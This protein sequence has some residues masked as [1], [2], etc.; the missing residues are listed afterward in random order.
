M[1][2]TTKTHEAI[3]PFPETELAV[4]C[5]GVEKSFRAGES[6]IHVL[7]ETDFWARSGEMTF[8]VGPS[9]CGKTTLISVF[10]AILSCEGGTV[11]V[12]GQDLRRTRRGR[13]AGFRLAN[14]GF[15]FQQF[16]LIPSLSAAENAS[17]PLVARGVAT[18]KAERRAAEMLERLG[19]KDQS[20]KMPAQLSGGQQQRVAIARA[21]V[22]DPKLLICDEPTASL[23]AASGK[24]V[25][26]LLKDV[27]LEEGRAVVVVTH[28]SRIFG[29]AD[30]VHHMADGQ[31]FK[32]ET[33]AQAAEAGVL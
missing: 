26:E 14:L 17:L 1:V 10:G 19:L 22:H 20:R 23:D 8:L 3:A 21:L 6:K 4:R 29:F 5:T 13:L 18:S 2:A 7:R 15:I 32:T 24:T 33:G 11:E 25:M 30:V 12:L 31:I 28:D 9:G 16:N 27:A